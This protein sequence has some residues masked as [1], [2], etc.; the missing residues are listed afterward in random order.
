MLPWTRSFPSSHSEIEC[1]SGTERT[2][3]GRA[4]GDR[5]GAIGARPVEAA[6]LRSCH[7]SCRG[8]GYTHAGPII[9][10]PSPGPDL[11]PIDVSR[12]PRTDLILLTTRPPMDDRD[13][14]DKKLIR[15]SFST[16]EEALFNPVL[17]RY[18]ARCARSEVLL[19]DEAA[20]TSPAIAERQKVEFRQNGG[21][22]YSVYGPLA[23]REWRYTRTA[24][25]PGRG[26]VQRVFRSFRQK[27]Q[28]PSGR[29]S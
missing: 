26:T 3:A 13:I 20:R 5:A 28:R 17:R 8:H 14:G 16:L 29:R 18:F 6:A 19:T 25:S 23:S 27:D 21:V 4:S 10:Y 2:P 11:I 12:L 15:R 1:R 9:N 22:G 24:S 7:R